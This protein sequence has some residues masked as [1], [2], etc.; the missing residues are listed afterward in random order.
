LAY[1]FFPKTATEIKLTLK[2]D[3]TKIDEIINVFAF[4]KDKFKKIETPINIDPKSISG[5]KLLR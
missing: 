1:T 3:N 5:K 2:G 4:L